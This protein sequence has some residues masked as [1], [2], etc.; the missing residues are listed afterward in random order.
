MAAAITSQQTAASRASTPAMIGEI[1]I[2][3]AGAVVR[4]FYGPAL[5]SLGLLSKTTIIDTSLATRSGVRAKR[6]IDD[7]MQCSDRHDWRGYLFGRC[8]VAQP[9]HK[10]C[11]GSPVP[12]T[13][14]NTVFTTRASANRTC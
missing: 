1:L 13:N 7:E 11:I 6:L 5:Q 12:G 10:N 2:L 8:D 4:W 9:A 14:R 3:G